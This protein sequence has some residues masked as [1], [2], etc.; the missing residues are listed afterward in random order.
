MMTS[1]E[2][3][4]NSLNHKE[5]DRI[6]IDL[7]RDVHNGIHEKAYKRLLDYLGLTDKIIL[8]DNIQHLAVIK[9]EVIDRLHTDTLYIFANS[10]STYEFKRDPDGSWLDEWGVRRKTV[11]LYDESYQFPLA[12]CDLKA[13]NSYKM[14]NPRDK[15]RFSGLREKAKEL[16]ENTDYA[17][18]GGSCG[19]LF[20]LTSELV[21]FQEYME[22]LLSDQE[23]IIR[24]VDRIIEWEA[25]FFEEYLAEIGEYIEMIWI[26][27]DW[28]MQNGPI[29]DPSLFRK[30]FVPRY[31][32]FIK[33]IKSQAD[34]KVAIHS[35]GS[36]YWALGDF[37]DMGIDVV[38][39]LQ[40]DAKDMNDPLRIKKEF[41]DRLV[42]YSNLCN[43]T[44]LPYGTVDEVDADVKRK[45]TALAQGGGYV[46]SGGH[47]IQADVPP[48]NV[49]A[50]V[51]A[52]IKYGRYPIGENNV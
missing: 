51:D 40:G 19:S 41:G 29:M 34:V 12:V 26:G 33:H 43:Q 16:Y 45:V 52:A 47:N 50:M 28:G 27:D 46:L 11:G 3:F 13:V 30:I 35:C 32:E 24:L 38:H 37:A 14:P 22:K 1:R 36:V 25:E 39:P 18:I 48:E 20:Y 4:R 42:L 23:V 49:L 9:Q 15:S 5:S 31:K 21:G 2:R 7:G 10:S 44:I 17:L 6:P 8:Y